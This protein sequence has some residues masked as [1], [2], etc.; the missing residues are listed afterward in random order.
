MVIGFPYLLKLKGAAAAGEAKA[1][2]DLSETQREW[3]WLVRH[4]R[5][6]VLEGA[7]HDVA[8]AD[9]AP[10]LGA[11]A[12]PAW[13]DLGPLAGSMELAAATGTR[14]LAD[15]SGLGLPG[16]LGS[17][18]L[19][20]RLADGVQICPGARLVGGVVCEEDVFVGTGAI[21]IPGRTI[22]ARTVVGAGAVVIRDLGPDLIAV[23]NPARAK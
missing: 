17:L 12:T 18:R 22:G 7:D 19:E 10:S 13:A 16:G 2:E 23:G 14:S 9:N 20:G 3:R 21:V 6:S 5:R 11:E 4:K 1:D 15:P 8:S